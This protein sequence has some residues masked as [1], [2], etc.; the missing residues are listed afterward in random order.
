MK[1]SHRRFVFTGMACV[2]LFFGQVAG[3]GNARHARRIEMKKV[4]LELKAS[5]LEQRYCRDG[6]ESL[7]MELL[8]R[9]T[10]KGTERLILYKESRLIFGYLISRSVKA[11]ARKH[12]LET[13]RFEIA[14]PPEQE[15]FDSSGPGAAFAILEPGASSM[16]HSEVDIPIL[17]A[18]YPSSGFLP[19]GHYVLQIQV[20]TWLQSPELATALRS[21]WRKFGLLWYRPV[22][23]LPM[24]FAVNRERSPSKCE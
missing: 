23:S 16:T 17:D 21:R 20:S 24:P 18:S 15:L 4:Q 1:R 3:K 10:N 8:L 11:A 7:R 13:V 12:Y 19:A 22:T 14:F 6:G 9:Y 2:F 5:V